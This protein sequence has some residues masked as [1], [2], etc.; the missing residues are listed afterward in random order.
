MIMMGAYTWKIIE[1]RL[2]QISK[3]PKKVFTRVII[4]SMLAVVLRNHPQTSQ[5][6]IV[7][8][9]S[10]TSCT[11]KILA[12]LVSASVFKTV[13]PFNASSAVTPNKP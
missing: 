1:K 2:N 11:R 7:S 6:L 13:V 10:F 5:S 4:A 12:P 9:A 3:F 8:T